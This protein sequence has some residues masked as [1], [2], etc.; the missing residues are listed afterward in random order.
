MTRD[1]KS[2]RLPALPPH[3]DT[4]KDEEIAS[5]MSTDEEF[6]NQEANVDVIYVNNDRK[7]KIFTSESESDLNLEFGTEQS[8]DVGDDE[9]PPLPIKNKHKQNV[10]FDEKQQY[11]IIDGVYVFKNVSTL[12][13]SRIM[14]K[15]RNNEDL[16][17]GTCNTRCSGVQPGSSEILTEYRQKLH[18]KEWFHE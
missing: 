1:E 2:K 8:V 11:Q 5:M 4:K 10:L 6:H 3:Y 17:M 7:M 14:S 15:N 12:T 18:S 16:Y 9:P 13:V